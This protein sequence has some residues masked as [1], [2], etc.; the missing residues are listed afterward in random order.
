M[1]RPTSSRA[2]RRRLITALVI[3]GLALSWI[4]V[5]SL[6]DGRAS[7]RA[8]SPSPATSTRLAAPAS[9][10]PSPTPTPRA[11]PTPAPAVVAAPAASDTFAATTSLLLASQVQSQLPELRNGCEATTL[12]MLLQ[13]VGRPVSRL[14]LAREQP[15]DATQPVFS[16][17][18]PGFD[19]I[20]SWGNPNRSFVG[21]VDRSYGY[22]IYHGPLSALLER[23]LP[24]RALDLSGKRFSDVLAQLRTGIPVMLWTTTTLRPTA[25]WVTWDTPDGPFR[26]TP[27]EH[28][29]LLV[30]YTPRG[31]IVNDP[32]A[33]QQRLVSAA[34]FIAAWQQ[35]GRQAVSVR[36]AES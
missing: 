22:G 33:G 18:G 5:R 26:A 28:A 35:L 20:I 24:G 10:R 8:G 9:P 12:S 21:R 7:P 36:P 3:T 1:F 23:Q 25:Q 31:L 4:T 17:A 34:P 30:G 6:T 15:T 14:T 27:Y 2:A 11:A 19:N 32:L 16:S 13:A 29:V